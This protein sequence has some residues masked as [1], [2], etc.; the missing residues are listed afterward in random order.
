MTNQL[1]SKIITEI[2]A[3]LAHCKPP[4]DKGHVYADCPFCGKQAK[5]GKFFF[6]VNLGYG[7]CYSGKCANGSGG[8]K[9]SLQ[10][11][12]Q[13]FD[14]E[15]FSKISTAKTPQW[16]YRDKNNKILFG[17]LRSVK[18]GAKTY[19]QM[20]YQNG[21]WV[22]GLK[23]QPVLYNLPEV[24]QAQ[25]VFVAEGEKCCDIIN[26]HIKKGKLN[27]A[28]ATTNP[29]GAGKWKKEYSAYLSGK[30]IYILPDNDD[31]KNNYAGQKHSLSVLNNL[32]EATRKQA[33]IVV[34]SELQKPKEDVF[35]WFINYGG[36]IEKLLEISKTQAEQIPNAI[37]EII[38]VLQNKNLLP[39]NKPQLTE[40]QNRTY[41]LT[42][43]G[44]VRRFR[45]AYKDELIF[46][47]DSG[48]WIRWDGKVYQEGSEHN[49]RNLAIDLTRKMYQ[50]AMIGSDALID[51]NL[52]IWAMKSQGG[53]RMDA[54]IRFAKGYFEKHP[55]ELD[56]DDY[57][58]NCQNGVLDLNSCQLLPHNPDYKM[59]KI[60]PASFNLQAQAPMFTA[61]L[62][63][64]MLGNLEMM[65]YLQ[66][67]FGLCLSG[68][69]CRKFFIFYGSGFNGKTVL[70][71]SI[72][73]ILGG[74][75]GSIRTEALLE[76]KY[77]HNSNDI[78]EIKGLRLL[79]MSEAN[80]GDRLNESI[81]KLMTGGDEITGRKLYQNNVKFHPVC[82]PIMHTNNR[83]R[84]SGHD[85]AIWDRIRLVPFSFEFTENERK[86]ADVVIRNFVENEKDGIF[87]WIYQGWLKVKKNNFI[88]NE[89]EM[90]KQSTTSYKR[91]EDILADF[92]LENCITTKDEF[93]KLN[94]S[95]HQRIAKFKDI[96]QAYLVWAENNKEKPISKTKLG[97]ILA[98]KFGESERT[99]GGIK[100]YRGIDLKVLK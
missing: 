78:A 69:V 55:N 71:E 22:Y 45:D 50:E 39:E 51:K 9:Y 98:T 23:V 90:V 53:Q 49:I 68:M 79:I 24:I 74:Y 66:Q 56:K 70:T 63:K 97:R 44:N 72:S 57:L 64:I 75:A 30:T 76:S 67:I 25:T 38:E 85:N 96:H 20:T 17:V 6:N 2:N 87:A 28:V 99:T 16:A 84:I 36:T 31:E 92:L 58:I 27:N 11:L 86:P 91:D 62:D 54:M 81:I 21:Q 88:L 80:E 3:N 95:Q 82:K 5:E 32:D 34:L 46:I 40:A 12:A 35:D 1:K 26:E 100:I 14:I 47:F 60:S 83:P 52:S 13:K 48:P 77:N 73:R 15:H 7:M 93:D 33:K 65:D 61:F 37:A 43:V 41:E 8:K 19:R 89:P 59:T 4:N 10:D 42:D 18:N 29:M 94:I